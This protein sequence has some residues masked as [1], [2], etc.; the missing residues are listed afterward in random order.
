[1]L[2]WRLSHLVKERLIALLTPIFETVPW[3]ENQKA[4]GRFLLLVISLL[5][6][7]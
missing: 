3:E 6:K 1:M 4:L 2:A 5:F 7:F